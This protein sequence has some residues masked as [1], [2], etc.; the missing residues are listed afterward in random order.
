MAFV[1]SYFDAW[2][3]HDAGLVAEHLTADGTYCD[4]PI[5]EQHSRDEL[6]GSLTH[7]FA[8]NNH[9]YKL[10]GE[11]LK[12]ETTIAFQYRVSQS[13]DSADSFFGS[14]FMTIDGDGAIRI[15]DYY[16]MPDQ[17]VSAENDLLVSNGAFAQKY[18]KSGLSETQMEHYKQRLAK[19]MRIEMAFLR[20]DLTLPTLA[21]CVDC[22]VNHLSQVINSGYGMSFFDYLNHH[23]VDYAKQLLSDQDRQIQ[24]VL[25]IALAAGF[26][27][28]SS[29]YTAF[30]KASGQTPAQF[31][32]SQTSSQES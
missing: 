26:N 28:N 29:F 18:T 13:D 15:L 9:H 17:I 2:N 23:R 12:G 27:S 4:I 7:F 6:L 31:R 10:I 3:L 14:E 21:T 8:S 20:P 19:L 16:S 25:S 32:Q 30:R 22:S 1:E 24:S 11:V 5:H